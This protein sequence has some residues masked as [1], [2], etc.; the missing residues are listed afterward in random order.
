MNKN[1]NKFNFIKKAIVN[2]VTS[3]ACLG[4]LVLVFGSLPV[5]AQTAEVNNGE[6]I[7][8]KACSPQVTSG[9]GNNTKGAD[10]LIKC[11]QQVST[12]LLIFGIILSAILTVR[13]TLQGYIP[14]QEIN[15]AQNF[16]ERIRSLVIGVILISLPGAILSLF[17]PAATGLDFLSGL[18]GLRR[19]SGL[20]I[21]SSGNTST[22]GT[23]TNGTTNVKDENDETGGNTNQD[24]TN[25][26]NSRTNGTD[27][28]KGSNSS[29]GKADGTTNSISTLKVI[30]AYSTPTPVSASA[31]GINSCRIMYFKGENSQKQS[32]LYQFDACAD[33]NLVN[34]YTRFN[35][36]LKSS[37][38]GPNL[39]QFEMIVG[40]SC[41][42]DS[43]VK[44]TI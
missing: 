35:D 42:F 17:N 9:P 12:I 19:A 37:S 29:T 31:T 2:L 15:S 18:E 30:Q 20:N 1:R 43:S 44:N 32:A 36:C 41:K 21:G 28:T 40:S 27:T 4:F 23:S 26:N 3:L 25:T 6:L 5:K 24:T 22:N 39:L 10:L 34:Y 16:R 14:G 8:F 38:A 11:I 7:S 13:D 33:K